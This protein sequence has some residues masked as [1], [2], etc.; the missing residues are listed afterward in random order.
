MKEIKHLIN[1]EFVG[2]ASG[3]MFDDINPATGQV[4]ARVHEGGKAEIDAAVSAARAALKGPWG[5]M[6][7]DQR[8]ALLRQVAEGIQARADGC[9]PLG[10]FIDI[11]QA[12]L[13]PGDAL[14]H[15]VCVAAKFLTQCQGGGVLRV[16]APD[17]DDVFEFF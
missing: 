14:G 9:A 2:S 6:P 1:G 16:G 12:C 17:L 8:M 5:T 13:D 15:L 3:K 4:I 10:Q 11:G 7:L